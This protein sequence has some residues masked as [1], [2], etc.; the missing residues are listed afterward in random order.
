MSKRE[1]KKADLMQ[2]K[3]VAKQALVLF[4]KAGATEK[5]L[6]FLRKMSSKPNVQTWINA[7]ELISVETQVRLGLY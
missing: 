1:S 4:R 7:K 6:G 2:I 3:V 5:E